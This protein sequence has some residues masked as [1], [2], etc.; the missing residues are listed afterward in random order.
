MPTSCVRIAEWWN[1]RRSVRQQNGL[2]LDFI[3]RRH[4]WPL[5]CD[6][7]KTPAEIHP[8]QRS[9]HSQPRQ[10]PVLLG[11]SQHT[12]ECLKTQSRWTRSIGNRLGSTILL[13]ASLSS[14]HREGF[15][16]LL[17]VVRPV[18]SIVRIPLWPDTP[19]LSILKRHPS[20]NERPVTRWQNRP[21][22]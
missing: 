22:F 2:L 19:P 8:T 9:T 7:H 18:A 17:R 5:H 4:N 14:R 21:P 11:P 16:W 12:T 13:R 3:R 1:G 10:S 15:R 20:W 6:R